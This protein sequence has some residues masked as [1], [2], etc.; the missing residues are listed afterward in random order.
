MRAFPR[1][2]LKSTTIQLAFTTTAAAT[3]SLNIFL[4]RLINIQ[5]RCIC[6]GWQNGDVYIISYLVTTLRQSPIVFWASL[7]AYRQS[8]RSHSVC[9]SGRLWE[10][11]TKAEL[12]SLGPVLGC[13]SDQSHEFTE[14]S[15]EP[16]VYLQL[17][18]GWR[19]SSICIL[20]HGEMAAIVE[21][22]SQ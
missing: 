16:G 10:Y 11:D 18:R 3:I 19:S 9:W 7:A 14:R 2:C 5:S 6:T 8:D 21:K 17:A 1:S 13:F 20:G 12:S 4:A 15:I 22:N